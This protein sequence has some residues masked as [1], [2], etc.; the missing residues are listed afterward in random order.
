MTSVFSPS[1]NLNVSWDAADLPGER[2]ENSEKSGAMTRC[3]N[4]RI[5]QRGK[6][7]LRD[8]ST[9]INGSAIETA[10]YW[11]EEMDGS[12]FTFAGTNI[13]EDESSLSSAMTS[14]QWSA[15]QYNAFNDTTKQIFALNGT[16]RVRVVSGS[17][18]EWGIDAPTVAP[19][20]STG[21]GGG[22]TGAYNA[23]Y[24]YVR[25]VGGA[26]V[27]ES[28][29]SPAADLSLTLNDQSLS[30]DVT[31]ST[32]SQVTHIRIY[33]SLAGGSIYYLD[34]EIT[35]GNAYAYG[36]SHTWEAD[37]AYIAGNNYKFTVNDST[38]STDNT[39]TWEETFASREDEQEDSTPT[40]DDPSDRPGVIPWWRLDD[41]EG[42]QYEIP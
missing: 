35:S 11:I 8:G 29:P 21:A 27:A 19:T 42:Q 13:Y 18:N 4:V 2:S 5:D 25:K 7:F 9:K 33:R 32:D 26:I 14:A 3:K 24:T 31:D 40:F 10:I 28:N 1:G 41:D 37:D 39:Y 36:N 30:V 38:N 20:L 17:V 16:D 12:R 23:R 22:L 6:S 34:A 15:M